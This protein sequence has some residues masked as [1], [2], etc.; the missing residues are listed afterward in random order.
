MIL[1]ISMMDL[2]AEEKRSV[3][4]YRN[5]KLYQKLT[6]P[7]MLRMLPKWWAISSYRNGNKLLQCERGTRAYGGPARCLQINTRQHPAVSVYFSYFDNRGPGPGGTIVQSR[8]AGG[9]RRRWSSAHAFSREVGEYEKHV[10][11]SDSYYYSS[12]FYDK[13]WP[14]F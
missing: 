13:S 4:L 5:L 11:R 7:R 9:L 2:D 3:Y 14:W 8:S 12:V 1:P 10:Q 6:T